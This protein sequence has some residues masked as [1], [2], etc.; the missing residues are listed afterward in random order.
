MREFHRTSVGRRQ[1]ASVELAGAFLAAGARLRFA[2][3]FLTGCAGSVSPMLPMTVGRA[4][5]RAVVRAPLFGAATVVAGAGVPPCTMTLLSRLRGTTPEEASDAPT[6]SLVG[7]STAAPPA[8]D[9]ANPTSTVMSVESG[10]SM[11]SLEA[12]VRSAGAGR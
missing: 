4:A 6:T 8:V 9:L 10:V 1:G 11:A 3:T 5:A 7:R 12:A 2:T